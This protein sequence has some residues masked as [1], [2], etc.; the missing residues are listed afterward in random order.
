MLFIPKLPLHLCVNESHD[1]FS[2]NSMGEQKGKRIQRLG[3]AFHFVETAKEK[4]FSSLWHP[5]EKRPSLRNK[6]L[7]TAGSH[8][9]ES[10]SSHGP[11][12]TVQ[13]QM[14]A[15]MRRQ[16]TTGKHVTEIQTLRSPTL[17]AG[18]GNSQEKS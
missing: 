11:N 2:I 4:L 18:G 6:R 5:S 12:K 7:S 16:E 9:P 15:Q 13:T 14:S 10:G 17:R 8:H 1:S 3:L